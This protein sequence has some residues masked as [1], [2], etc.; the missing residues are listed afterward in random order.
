M[1]TKGSTVLNKK[2]A[3][4]TFCYYSL[5]PRQQWFPT[6]FDA[7]LPLLTLELFIPPLFGFV[8]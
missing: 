5:H 6:F 1:P 2:Y 7:F 3:Y 8:G 4:K